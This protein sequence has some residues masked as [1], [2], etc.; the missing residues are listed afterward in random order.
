MTLD[1][2][3]ADVLSIKII[4]LHRQECGCSSEL[5]ASIAGIEIKSTPVF[6]CNVIMY[7]GSVIML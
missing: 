3:R 6:Q 7:C 5:L 4:L 1:D 2:T